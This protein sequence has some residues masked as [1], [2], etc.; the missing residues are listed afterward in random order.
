MKLVHSMILG[1]AGAWA[2]WQSRPGDDLSGEVALVTGGSRGLGFLLARRLLEQ[3]CTVVICGRDAE[4]LESARERL[5][6][7]G[8][9]GAHVCDVSD[10]DAVERLVA[11]IHADHG[12]IDLLVNNAAIIQVGPLEALGHDDFERVMATNFWGVYNTTRAVLPGMRERGHGRIANVASIGGRVAV[13]HLL[14]YDSAKFAVIGFSEG[15]RAELAGTNVNVLTIVPGLMRTGSPVH[16]AV[17][18]DHAAEFAWFAA[19]DMLP[20]TS[21]SAE[22]AADRIV[23]AIR[24]NEARVTLSWQAKLLE[25][26]HG[27]APDVVMGAMAIANRL[28]PDSPGTPA[29]RKTRR[30]REVF[31]ALPTGWLRRRLIDLGRRSHQPMEG[32]AP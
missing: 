32:L 11:R 20:F 6:S 21:M 22:R 24:R 7:T 26:A 10:R 3:G 27:L 18:G 29:A 15:L 8:Q 5:A 13:P 12:A 31:D 30:G 16:V 2:L 4:R 1:G 23:R 25:T 28:L 19:A 14:P 9:V 17:K